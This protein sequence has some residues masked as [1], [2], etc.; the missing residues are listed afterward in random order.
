MDYNQAYKQGYRYIARNRWGGEAVFKH[1]PKAFN[2]TFWVPVN[3]DDWHFISEGFM[4]PFD[5]KVHDLTKKLSK[6]AIVYET[7]SH[8][9]DD[10]Y[11]IVCGKPIKK[12]IK[13]T[14]SKACATALEAQK[15]FFKKGVLTRYC[16]GCGKPFKATTTGHKSCSSYCNNVIQS[17]IKWRKKGS[18][19]GEKVVV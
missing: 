15:L 8:R 7:N 12:G 10:I 1:K 16:C 14:C 3:A 11:C 2:G 6:V 17:I 4:I 9:H 18:K 5:G 13:L 19:H